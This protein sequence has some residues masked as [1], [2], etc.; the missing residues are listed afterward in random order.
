MIFFE[1]H[2]VEGKEFFRLV[3]LKNFSF[4]LHFHMAFEIIYVNCGHLIIS[5]D[6]KE[7]RLQKDD[8]AFVFPNQIHEFVTEDYSEITVILFSTELIGDFFMNYKGRVPNNSILHL[9]NGLNDDKLGTTYSQKSFLY[10]ICDQFVQKKVFIPVKQSIQTK[11]LHKI[12]LYVEQN[13]SHDFNLKDVAKKLQYD[14]PYISKLF[15]RQMD[16]TFTQYLNNYRI[17]QACYLLKNSEKSIGDIA[18]NCGYN[19]LKTFHRN[20]RKTTNQS[21]RE[22][23]LTK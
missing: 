10:Y 5:I 14:Y 6:Q 7:Y 8:L 23:R 1:K 18:L 4:P 21:P 19:N 11:L 3:P 2:G 13:Y 15:T 22:Y 9:E 17:S 20:F 16:I 12:I